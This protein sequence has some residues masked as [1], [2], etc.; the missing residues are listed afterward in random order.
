MKRAFSKISE[1]S[2]S[3]CWRKWWWVVQVTVQYCILYME[4]Q[5]VA[6]LTSKYLVHPPKGP[7]CQG[8]THLEIMSN[9]YSR[10]LYVQNSYI[11]RI[12]TFTMIN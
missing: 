2:H 11:Q 3:Q 1:I 12:I 6:A 10:G 7:Q 5:Y 9:S 4:D 8:L